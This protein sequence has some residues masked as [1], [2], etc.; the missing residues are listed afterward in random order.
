M[1][2]IVQFFKNIHKAAHA[3]MNVYMCLVIVCA[4]AFIMLVVIV[5][6]VI[7]WIMLAFVFFVPLAMLARIIYAGITGR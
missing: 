2:K 3:D 7:V 4:I 6:K 1:N 5:P